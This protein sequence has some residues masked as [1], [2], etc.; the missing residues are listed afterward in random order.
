LVATTTTP[1]NIAVLNDSE[2][3]KK[4]IQTFVDAY[5][6]V[7]TSLAEQVKYDASSKRSGPLQGDRAATQ[8]QSQ[9]REM[10]RTSVSSGSIA[11]LSEIGIQVQ[12]DATLSVSGSKLEAALATPSKVAT[13]FQA[14]DTV[15]PNAAGVA[16]RLDNR[17]TNWLGSSGTVA[18]ADQTL[19][20]LSKVNQQQQDS[21]NRRLESIQKSLLRTYTS[22]DQ[23]LTQ[24][25][26]TPIPTVTSS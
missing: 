12:R 14:I 4:T 9:L 21:L 19:T 7:T 26:S 11:N 17:I 13:L 23:Q 22:L 25:K 16:R 3:M 24:I 20:K 5:N 15:N 18:G 8:L 1:V 6:A 10:L 2:A